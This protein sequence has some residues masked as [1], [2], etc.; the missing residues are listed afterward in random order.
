[1]KIIHTGE[2]QGGIRNG[3]SLVCDLFCR[4]MRGT[5]TE[6]GTV[7]VQ[8]FDESSDVRE[9]FLVFPRWETGGPDNSVKFCD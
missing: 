9:I 6:N 4:G 1:M 3:A 7:S 2:D 8:F 5:E